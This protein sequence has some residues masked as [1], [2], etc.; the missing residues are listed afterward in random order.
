MLVPDPAVGPV[1]PGLEVGDRAVRSGKELLARRGCALRAA[2]MVVAVLGQDPVGLQAVRVHDRARLSAARAGAGGARGAGRSC[3]GGAARA[4]GRRG[5][6]LLNQYLL[7]GGSSCEVVGPR[8]K[9]DPD[10]VAVRHGHEAGE[11]TLGS[12][13]LRSSARGRAAPMEA[14]RY[15]WP[16]T[17]TSPIATRSRAWCSSGCSLASRRVASR[18]PRSRSARRSSETPARPRSRRL[19]LEA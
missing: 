12:R 19:A 13:R 5:C 3:E 7:H 16:P 10:R 6:D 4:V 11:V 17:A 15:R 18:A 1:H 9:H 14:T 2:P 8:S